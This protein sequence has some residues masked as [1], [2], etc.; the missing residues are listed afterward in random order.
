MAAE[1]TAE[2]MLAEAQAHQKK[3]VPKIKKQERIFSTMESDG[4]KKSGRPK[5]PLKPCPFNCGKEHP[6]GSGA[7]CETFRNIPDVEE[8][9]NIVKTFGI[10]KCCLKK[11]KHTAEKPCRAKLCS[12]GAAHHE[13]LC[14]RKKSIQTIHKIKEQNNDDDDGEER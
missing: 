6:W 1:R 5:G 4:N 13:L 2:S 9:I 11:M 12:C 8:R 3:D 10:N 7:F 14:K